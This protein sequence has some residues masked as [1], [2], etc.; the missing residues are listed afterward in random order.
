ML[1]TNRGKTEIRGFGGVPAHG[2][3]V[4]SDKL[5]YGK[6][7]VNSKSTVFSRFQSFFRIK[8]IDIGSGKERKG[9]GMVSN[10]IIEQLRSF[11]FEER[12]HLMEILLKSIKGDIASSA[13]P[14]HLPKIAT[15]ACPDHLPKPGKFK[16]RTFNLG[17]N[18]EPDRDLMYSE[19]GF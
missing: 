5:R 17:Q 18:L 6:P 12:I 10:E 4:P 16:V 13:C 11:S 1:P 7:V 8:R 2:T 3:I 14:D 19:R 9:N 15:S